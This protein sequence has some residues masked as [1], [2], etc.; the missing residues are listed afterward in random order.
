MS[1]EKE[2]LDLFTRVF[3]NEKTRNNYISRLNG[4][5]HKVGASGVLEVVRNPEEW[6]PKLQ[7]GYPSLTT[8]RNILTAILV[9]FREDTELKKLEEVRAKW[10]KWHEDLGRHEDARVRRSEP[11]DKQIAKYTS[12]EEIEAKYAELKDHG[13]HKTRQDSLQ[14]VLLS[15]IVHLRPKRADLGDVR[16]FKKDP[17]RTDIN[18]I[19]LRSDA[20]SF[21]SMNIY[22]TSKHYKKIEE[23]LPEGLVR[24]IRVSVKRWP[25]EYLFVKDAEKPQG[26]KEP[27]NNSTYSAFV[28]RTFEQLF[29]RGTGVSLLRHI[30]ISEKLN[31]DN[32]T[33]EEQ[34]EEARLMLHT[35]GLQRQYK[36]PKK[37]IC[38]KLCGEYMESVKKGPGTRKVSRHGVTHEKQADGTH[39]RTLRAKRQQSS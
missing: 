17:N 23:E 24:D 5:I 35:S 25:R 39:R 30:Y 19:V 14:Y 29:G 6:Y 9:L 11:A 1:V 26:G 7:A 36:W 2:V 38:P 37:V 34:E 4:M 8:R 13:P 18:Y 3:P 16:L 12:F 21:L 15:V 10:K 31:L 28:Q 32:M 27:M 33:L 22:K 20:S